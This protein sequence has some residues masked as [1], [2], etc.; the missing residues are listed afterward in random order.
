[1]R[2]LIGTLRTKIIDVYDM[3]G[4]FDAGITDVA[5]V[6]VIGLAGDIIIV[7]NDDGL[8][9]NF[10]QSFVVFSIVLTSPLNKLFEAFR[11]YL[12]SCLPPLKRA[13]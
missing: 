8:T 13:Q 10:F 1:M 12:C 7:V 6:L 9:H 2:L 3:M 4:D 5:R 11:L